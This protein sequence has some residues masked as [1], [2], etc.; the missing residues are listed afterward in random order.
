MAV[1]NFKPVQSGALVGF[2]DV[3]LPSG[4]VLLRCQIF[5]KDDRAWA[6]PPA[7]QVIGRDGVVQRTPD[8]KVRYE[9]TVSFTDRPTQDRWSTAVIAAF[10]LAYPEVL[11]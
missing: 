8:G 7:K 2:L 11:A 6:A 10:K 4:L 5:A 9:P 1:D 3:I